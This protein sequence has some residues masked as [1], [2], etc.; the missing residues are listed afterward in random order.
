MSVTICV[1]GEGVSGLKGTTVK[2]NGHAVSIVSDAE[3]KR[4]Q[5]AANAKRLDRCK[6]AS[7]FD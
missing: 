5:G 2:R 7:D 1:T 4:I 6:E 3:T